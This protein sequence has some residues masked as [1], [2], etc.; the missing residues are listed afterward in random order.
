MKKIFLLIALSSFALF[1]N[2][3]N[4]VGIGTTTP[5]PNAILDLQS[6]TNDQGLLVP[7]LTTAERTAAAF[8]TALAGTSEGLVVYDTDLTSFQY[9]DGSVWNAIG[10]SDND[11][12]ENNDTI[13]N[14][15]HYVVV[16]QTT[17]LQDIRMLVVSN[18]IRTAFAGSSGGDGTDAI[19]VQGYATSAPNMN[20]GVSG[21]AESSSATDTIIGTAGQAELTAGGWGIGVLGEAKNG[22]VGG[23]GVFGG[24]EGSGSGT[25]I[26]VF[27][28]AL[29]GTDNWAGYF[30]QGDVFIQNDLGI[31]I[32]PTAKLDIEAPFGSANN[33]VKIGEAL[34]TN[35]FK[36]SSGTTAYTFG[37]GNGAITR[38]DIIINHTTANVGI[39][40]GLFPSEKLEIIGRTKT[41]ELEVTTGAGTAGNVLTDD[42]TGNAVW[43]AAAASADWAL[44]GNA[45]SAGQILGTTNA[46]DLVIQS[47]GTTA[48]TIDDATQNIGIGVNPFGS[49][50]VY[51]RIPSSDASVHT[52]Y[53]ILHSYSGASTKTGVSSAITT[54][55]AGLKRAFYGTVASTGTQQTTGFYS[56]INNNGSGIVQ[57]SYNDLNS[58]NGSGAQYG[59]Y[60]IM[61][62]TGSGTRTGTL[63]DVRQ[64]SGATGNIVNGVHNQV[65]TVGGGQTRGTFNSISSTGSGTQYGS[66]NSMQNTGS[67]TRYGTNNDL[68]QTDGSATNTMFG[69]YTYVDHSGVGATTYGDFIQMNGGAGIFKYGV[70]TLGEDQNYFSGDVRFNGDLLP[71]GLAGNA[72]EV[73]TSNGTGTTPTWTTPAA[74]LNIYNSDGSL[75]ADRI[76]T[77]G[78]NTLSFTTTVNNGFNV[79]ANTLSIDGE[80]NHVGIGNTIPRAKLQVNGQSNTSVIDSIHQ[81]RTSLG[82]HR[83][84]MSSGDVFDIGFQTG[85]YAAWMQAGYNG[86][87]EAILL[88]PN[89]GNVAINH[90]APSSALD[91]NGNVE[92]N[93]D[94]RPNNLPG[95]AGQVLTSA[96]NGVAPTWTAAATGDILGVTAGTGL[97]GGGTS[98]TPT[99]NVIATNGLTANANDIRLGGTLVQA[100]TINQS[101]N[102]M[103]FNLNSTG[104]F[105]VMD[106]AAYRMIVQDGGNV[107][108]GTAT[109]VE[110]LEVQSTTT[111]SRIGLDHAANT[112]SEVNFLEAGVY[113]GAVGY[114][115]TPGQDY[116]YLYQGGTAL[117]A[118]NGNVMISGTADPLSNLQI[119]N[120]VATGALNS[121]GEYQILL[122]QGATA[123]TSYGIGIRSG[124]LVFNT[125]DDIHF[126]EE[127]VTRMAIDNGNVGIGTTAPKD[128]LQV[129]GD[130][131]LG[132]G[133][134]GNGLNK[135]IV[136]YLTNNSGA[137]RVLGD[138]VISS[139]ANGFSVTTSASHYSAIGVLTEGCTA[140]SVCKVAVAGVTTVRGGGAIGRH[141]ITSTT[142]GRAGNTTTPTNGTSIGVFLTN[143]TGTYNQVLLR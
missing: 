9:W 21:L 40:T 110:L 99:L 60:N 142:L 36:I 73:L 98:G 83:Y 15:T 88:N 119:V 61:Q 116:V 11:W 51:T 74:N 3:Q 84:T 71:D 54:D 4:S 103:T 37:G 10:G 29:G 12:I 65:Q 64:T 95:T 128:K 48:M 8:M 113:R 38:H 135:A 45:I 63:N 58:S 111:N 66:Y 130:V 139:G 59:V 23:Y 7:R 77:G 67:G 79:D 69:A 114:S 47:G 19:G 80:A 1:S 108:I 85:T 35:K 32:S 134:A 24:A 90:N 25:M 104:D 101:T 62:N 52:A 100:T 109:P 75:S 97:T 96:G 81:S 2:A 34:T 22:S 57:G 44:A 131:G 136:V 31:G 55:G 28:Q 92:F 39:G 82:V 127:G 138:I 118:K 106:G 42:G 91:V 133:A 16:G 76:V 140:G 68:R 78:A 6:S 137:S 20:I 122:Y 141:C 94:L 93:G 115:S 120:N 41:D 70:Y 87:A 123:T 46:Q 125:N 86:A 13:Y 129:N 107:G 27:G 126:D 14:N 121:F 30:D 56:L 124:T 143:S 18:G 117:T 112:G 26:G 132:S 105:R 50:K 5:D 89:G 53:E 33:I 43:S 17:M 72:G 102:H 49:Y